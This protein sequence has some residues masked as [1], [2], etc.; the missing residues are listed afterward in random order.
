MSVNGNN[1]RFQGCS[2]EQNLLIHGEGSRLI[3]LTAF[4]TGRA[5]HS[6]IDDLSWMEKGKRGGVY[7][8]RVSFRVNQL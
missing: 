4:T 2:L 3:E 5:I 1:D 8:K 7:E 6:S